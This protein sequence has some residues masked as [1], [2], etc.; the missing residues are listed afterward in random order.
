[1]RILSTIS[2]VAAVVLLPVLGATT[3]QA[4]PAD[5]PWSAPADTPWAAP[6]DTPWTITTATADTPW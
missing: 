6:L 2:A 3:A 1:M 4:A 5:T